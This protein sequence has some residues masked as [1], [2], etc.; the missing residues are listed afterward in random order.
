VKRVVGG[1]RRGVRREENLYYIFQS[2]LK[3]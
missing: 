2:F 1:F 3:I